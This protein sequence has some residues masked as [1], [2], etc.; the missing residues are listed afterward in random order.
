M[1]GAEGCADGATG[2]ES[3][4]NACAWVAGYWL[5]GV[6]SVGPGTVMGFGGGVGFG[7]SGCSTTTTG[8]TLPEPIRAA[9]VCVCVLKRGEMGVST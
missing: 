2:V 8:G 7:G 9:G 4:G 6:K 1:C 3:G 5:R